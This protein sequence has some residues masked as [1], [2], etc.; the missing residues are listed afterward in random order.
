MKYSMGN[1]A[2]GLVLGAFAFFAYSLSAE[3]QTGIG[4]EYG[5]RAPAICP[6]RTQP[7]EGA[8]NE[9]QLLYHLRCTMEGIG[10]GRLY[11][12]ENMI[13]EIS[14]EG[15]AHDPQRDYYDNI[16][17]S[18]LI[19]PISGSLLRYNCHVLD[20]TNEGTSCETFLEEEANGACY[21]ET[22]GDWVCRMSDLS[23]VRDDGAP[24]P[25]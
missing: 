16:D 20:G 19:Y 11:L 21:K 18:A 12:A 7:T 22:N 14:G 23:Q 8:P 1:L 10:D 4:T 15:R 13:A 5:S 24:P 3:A 2:L 17:T 25:L 9:E 6:D